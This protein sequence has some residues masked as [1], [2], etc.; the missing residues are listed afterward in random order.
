MKAEKKDIPL[1]IKGPKVMNLP[2]KQAIYIK[3]TGE[4]GSLDF[5]GSWQRL[6]QFVKEHKL[7]SMGMEHIAI[8]HDDPKVTESEKLR[9]DI[10]LVIK[11]DVKP[12][13]DIGVKEIKAGKFAMFLY[14][15]AYSNLDSVYDTIYARLLP[16]NNLQLRDYH[17]FEK[18]LNHPDKTVPEKLKTEIYIPVE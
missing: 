16:E 8:Y 10:C 9:T 12:Q 14:Q 2:A 18:Y 5:S 3:L 4:Y 17:C 6:W 1:K 11:K 15:G 13:A 7:F